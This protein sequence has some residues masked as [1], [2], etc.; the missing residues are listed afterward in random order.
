MYIKTLLE[1][2]GFETTIVARTAERPNL[3]CRVRG[4][5]KASPFL[6]Y[7]HVDVVPTTDQEWQVP[8]FEG[9][10]EDGVLW[11]RGAIDMKGPLAMMISAL[12]RAKAEGR[13]LPSDVIF[14]ALSDEEAGSEYGAK[15][16][17]QEHPE[18]FHGV[19]YAIGEFGATS[20]HMVGSRMYPIMVSEKHACWLKATI[21]GSAGHSA[22]LH[23]GGTMARVAQFLAGLDSGKLPVHVTSPAT[24][25]V[26]GLSEV[27]PFPYGAACKLLLIPSIT[28]RVINL[29]GPSGAL[30]VPLFHNS[31]NATIIRGGDKV[32]VVPPQVDIAL[33]CRLLPGYSVKDIIEEITEA[34][35]IR[36]EYEV[37]Q[38]EPSQG[39]PDMA[40]YDLIAGVLKESDPEGRPFPMFLSAI[41]DGRWFSKLGIQTYGFTPMN[42]PPDL[43]FTSVV[44]GSNERVPVSALDFGA[45]AIY[46][47]L[48]KLDGR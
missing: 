13:T 19:R 10:I 26:Q 32:N 17:V 31:V 34:T 45:D 47:L 29:L 38:E 41:T 6:M 36:A 8:P 12:L 48:Q 21:K 5:G 33:D 3:I 44:H 35:G 25:M 23:R 11:G 22:L 4:E 9:R 14:T 27:M 30:F 18:L 20:I 46:R 37:L 40:L 1:E 7:G 24:L 28:D 39:K 43:N 16:L 15:Y 2:F 42:L